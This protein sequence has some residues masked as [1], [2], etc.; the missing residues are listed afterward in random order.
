MRVRKIWDI[1]TSTPDENILKLCGNNRILA[2][3]LGNRG[4]NTEEKIKSFLNP[5]K[6]PLSSADVLT[7]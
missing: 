3:L 7:G 5:L 4:I 6:A 2:V 1:K